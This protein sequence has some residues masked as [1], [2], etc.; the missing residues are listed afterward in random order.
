MHTVSRA[1]TAIVGGF[2]ITTGV[3]SAA[4]AGCIDLTTSPAGA[5]SLIHAAYRPGP[6]TLVA[7]QDHGNGDDRTSI[8]GLWQFE[9]ISK[10]NANNP[11]PNPP[12]LVPLDS[13]FAQWHS[14]GTEIMNSSR[15]PATSN[16]CLGVWESDGPR[17]YILNHYALS[18][19]NT[20]TLCTPVG[21]APSCFVGPTNIR[22][23]VTV[24]PHGDTY[25]GTVKI[26]QYDTTGHAMFSLTGTV[27]AKRITPE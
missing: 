4:Y 6:V 10:G 17:T 11:P 23:R 26:T 16:V 1:V 13:G 22:E 7:D 5:P 15:D 14:D 25:A 9:F 21:T 24:D 2:L 8:V 27:S 19:D 18:W 3:A 12:D 20:R